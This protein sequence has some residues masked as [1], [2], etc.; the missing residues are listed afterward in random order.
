MSG[1]ELVQRFVE[2][3]DAE[4]LLEDEPTERKENA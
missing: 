2:E 1:E 4:E 3:F